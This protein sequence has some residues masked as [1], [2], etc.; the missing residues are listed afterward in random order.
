MDS[1]I[2]VL[3]L[4]SLMIDQIGMRVK[5]VITSLLGGVEKDLLATTEGVEK[6]RS[7]FCGPE[8]IVFG[9]WRKAFNKKPELSSRVVAVVIDEAHCVSKWYVKLAFRCE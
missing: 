6:T 3:P 7:L 2:I 5:A 1:I 9:R 8:A 4:L